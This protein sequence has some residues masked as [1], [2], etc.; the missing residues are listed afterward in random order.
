MKLGIALPS[1][2]SNGDPLAAGSIASAAKRIEAAGFDIDTQHFVGNHPPFASVDGLWAPDTTDGAAVPALL[3][4][5]GWVP[6][7]EQSP[8]RP[9]AP[10]TCTGGARASCG[11]MLPQGGNV[12]AA[13][14]PEDRWRFRDRDRCRSR[15][16]K[17]FSLLPA[18][19]A[20]RRGGLTFPAP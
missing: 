18:V 5:D 6:L 11:I 20:R 7:L 4:R 2:E 19:L 14:T 13:E 1:S 10:T 15:N 9:D 16:R 3:A 12:D 8:L 17:R